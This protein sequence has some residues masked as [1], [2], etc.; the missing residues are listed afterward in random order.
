VD[1]I[2]QEPTGGA[3]REP[4]AAIASVGAAIA[5]ALDEFAPLSPAELRTQRRDRFLAIG[6]FEAGNAPS[7]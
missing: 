7:V 3:H 6:R 2:I 5:E 4:A 1:A